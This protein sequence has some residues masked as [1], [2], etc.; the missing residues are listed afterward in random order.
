M[1]R[2]ESK[3]ILIFTIEDNCTF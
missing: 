1:L 2:H 3:C